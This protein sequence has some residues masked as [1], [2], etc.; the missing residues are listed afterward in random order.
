MGESAA[1]RVRADL[2]TSILV[3]LGS[4]EGV[5]IVRAADFLT[6]LGERA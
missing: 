2:D 1:A 3:S 5:R 4:Y 6:V